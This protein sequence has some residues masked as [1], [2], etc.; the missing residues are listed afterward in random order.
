MDS[1]GGMMRV[2]ALARAAGVKSDTIRFYE[3]IDCSSSRVRS[4]S[5]C[6]S[7]T[8]SG[9]RL[10]RTHARNLATRKEVSI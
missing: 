3:R 10:P 6:A 1:A 5:A 2:A 4:G 8:Y 7:R 9:G